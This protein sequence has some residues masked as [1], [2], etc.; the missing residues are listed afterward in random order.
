MER[1]RKYKRGE[2]MT[3]SKPAAVQKHK[4]Y[5]FLARTMARKKRVQLMREAVVSK[6]ANSWLL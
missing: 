3:V 5:E 2:E 1:D 4:A 6:D